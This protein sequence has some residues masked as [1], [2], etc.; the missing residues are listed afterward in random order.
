VIECAEL[1]AEAHFDYYSASID[2]VPD[3]IKD[4]VGELGG[5][6]EERR[7]INGYKTTHGLEYGDSL[8]TLSHGGVDRP[9]HVTAS[10]ISAVPVANI[11]RS[12]YP[13]HRVAR[14]DV[15]LDLLGDGLYDRAF[16][17]LRDLALKSGTKTSRAGDW[18][19]DV[20][21]RTFYVGA[22]SS[23]IRSRWYEKG[24]EKLA[25]NPICGASPDW[26]RF[27]VQVRPATSLMKQFAARMAPSEF[28]GVGRFT[29]SA[30]EALVGLEVK[31]AAWTNL[32]AS[33]TDEKAM[34]FLSRQYG[35]LLRRRRAELGDW[36][37]VWAELQALVESPKRG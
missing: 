15:A 4:A 22:P 26:S 24:R 13:N 21:A 20:P 31:K 12:T 1:M 19:S 25:E 6:W 28:F 7:P 9:P 36:G 18:D 35:P 32:R 16:P 3:W 5:E 37:S 11:I 34:H 17:V 30:V 14:V 27:E 23:Q 29:A 2:E 33:S 8:V 10:G